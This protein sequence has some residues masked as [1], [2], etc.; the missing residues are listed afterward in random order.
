[1]AVAFLGGSQAALGLQLLGQPFAH[2]WT[3]ELVEPSSALLAVMVAADAVWGPLSN[4]LLAVNRHTGFSYYFLHALV[5]SVAA[6]AL[7]VGQMGRDRHG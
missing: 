2:L 3:E 7:L 6:G 5:V 1:M 4:L